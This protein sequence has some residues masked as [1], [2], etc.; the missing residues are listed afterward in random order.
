VRQDRAELVVERRTA[1]GW[2]SQVLGAVDEL[3]LSG[4]G[5]ACPIKDVYR[6]TPLG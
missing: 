2:Q 4:F 5:L 1:D 6:D 3:V